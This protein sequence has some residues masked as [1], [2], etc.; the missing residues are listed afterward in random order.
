MG[1]FMLVLLISAA[2]IGIVCYFGK[3]RNDR[4][5]AEGKIISRKTNFYEFAEIFTLSGIDYNR[6]R[7]AVDNADFSDLK[8]TVYKDLDGQR[9]ILFR[10]GYEWNAEISF[11][12]ETDGKYRYRFEFVAWNEHNGIP[13]RMDTMN[14]METKVEK[15]LLSL[16]PSASVQS[17]ENKLTTKRSFF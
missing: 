6:I 7:S 12:G 17:V 2:I 4:L 3:Q 10:S 14:M 8:A 9:K 1:N 5:I 16:D 15:L 13:F 11:K